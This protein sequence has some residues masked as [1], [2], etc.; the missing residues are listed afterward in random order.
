MALEPDTRLVISQEI[1]VRTLPLTPID[2]FLFSRVESLC[3]TR[4]PTVSDVIAASGQPSESAERALVKLLELGALLIER[5]EVAP[6]RSSPNSSPNSSLGDDEDRRK[7]A[8]ERK[9]ALLTAQMRIVKGA[10]G[11][12]RPAS[13]PVATVH[14]PANEEHSLPTPRE[15]L[16]PEQPATKAVDLTPRSI[17]DEVEPVSEHDGRLVA[18]LGMPLER[19]RRLLALRDRL[20]HVGHFDL[21]GLDPTDDVKLIR[22]AYHVVSREFHQ[23]SYYGKELG[24]FKAVL[25]DLFRRARSSYEFLLDGDRRKILIGSHDAQARE[26]GDRGGDRSAARE[27]VSPERREQAARHGEQARRERKIGRH[28]TAATLFRLAHEQDPSNPSYGREWQASLAAARHQ[29]AELGFARGQEA[30]QAGDVH[31]AARHFGEAA[32]AEP[33]L[34]NLSQAA[35]VAAEVDPERARAFAT[36]ALEALEQARASDPRVDD[37]T[38]ASVH[39]ACARTFLALGQVAVAREQAERADKLGP[40]SQVRALLN[41]IKLT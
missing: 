23:D 6:A 20:R 14:P 17:L 39:L 28:G 31:D 41:S 26:G 13:R 19:Q 35:E 24:P 15:E 22:R 34:R 9:R 29:R 30:L 7:R 40:T 38:A 5:R 3:G 21:L 18:T 11:A 27:S 36:A 8:L 37:P 12:E 32:D 33:S 25:D 10:G 4:A 2:F 16:S 1:E